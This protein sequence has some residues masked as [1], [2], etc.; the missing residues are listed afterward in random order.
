MNNIKVPF[1]VLVVLDG[2]GL[3]SDG[4]GNAVAKANTPNLDKY[5]ATYPHCKLRASGEAVGL[6]RGEDGN[7]ETG[8]MN[9]GAGRIVYQDLP[10]INMSIADGTFFT[11][12]SFLT[13]IK[14]CKENGSNL[15]LIGLVGQ[16]GVHSSNDHLYALLKLAKDQSFERVYLHLFTDGRDSPPTSARFYLKQIEEEI[17]RMGVGKIASIVGRYYAMDRDNRWERT[18]V[19]YQLLTGAVGERYESWQEAIKASYEDKVTDEFIGP[20]VLVGKDGLVTTIKD[21]DGIIFFNYRI[22]R[23]RQLTKAFLLP[24]L[25]NYNILKPG[26]DP[27]TEKYYKK[28]QVEQKITKTFDRKV[29]LKNLCFVTMTCYED[30]ISARVAF[31]PIKIK[32]PLGKILSQEGMKQIRA[33]ETEKERF[34]TY[35]FNGQREDP[36]QGEDRIIIPSPNVAT[37]D[38]KPE[39]SAD[40]LTDSFISRLKA[41]DYQFGL[42]NFPNPDMVGHTGVFEA[43]VTA[44]EKVDECLGKIVETVN[45]LGG[46]TLITA[47]HGNCEEMINLKTGEVDTEHSN[48]PVPFVVVGKEFVNNPVSLSMGSLSDVAV[49]ALFL[50]GIEKGEEMTG[51]NLVEDIM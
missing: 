16:G 25:A 29:F 22:D 3:T 10:R 44:C 6:P 45:S 48:N 23:P 38:L 43:A 11:N 5:F 32:M 20:S 1:L 31:T 35:Y 46:C 39:M 9:L 37:Y 27:Y 28:T 42:L 7:S 40:D 15:H 36:F 30:N 21:N 19:A 49:T 41:R 24:D 13:C 12:E 33:T 8:H 18:Q 14:H 50:M 26:F 51:R 47:D 2:W 34:V 4:E 17:C